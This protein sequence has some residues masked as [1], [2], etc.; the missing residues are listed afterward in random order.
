ME[1]VD[2]IPACR[3]GREGARDQDIDLLVVHHDAEPVGGL[4]TPDAFLHRLRGEAQL[5]AVHRPRP[6]EHEREVDGW[7]LAAGA[8]L[9]G[10]DAGD[11]E[12]LAVPPG[13]DE[14]AVGRDREGSG[15]GRGHDVVLLQELAG[16]G[17]E[18]LDALVV[19]PA[20]G[21]ADVELDVRGERDALPGRAGWRRMARMAPW[22]GVGRVAAGAAMG[23]AA[24][25]RHGGPAR[26]VRE[27][28]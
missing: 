6:V 15:D 18:P 21:S 7:S 28:M 26:S 14:A 5:L 24:R 17:D 22:T 20:Q 2:G 4:E 27:R 13:A 25:C 16:D 10:A 8:S 19:E 3:L 12:S 23:A 9:R 11:D 1:P